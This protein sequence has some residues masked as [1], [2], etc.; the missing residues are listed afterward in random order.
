M[1]FVRFLSLR[2]LHP[3]IALDIVDEKIEKAKDFGADYAFNS[4]DPDLDKKIMEIC[5][6]GVNHILD[7]VGIPDVWN[8]MLP[9]LSE[10]SQLAAF[11]VPSAREGIIKWD[12]L[13]HWNFKLNFFQMSQ[14]EEE[15]W[16]QQQVLAAI[17]SGAVNLDDYISDYFSFEE[18]VPVLGRFL[19]NEFKMKTIITF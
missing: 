18:I 7:A 11:G 5:P 12:L 1:S 14:A 4:A 13:K 9:M 3:I 16:A 2:G 8:S 15:G 19:K 17:K 10:N 6:N